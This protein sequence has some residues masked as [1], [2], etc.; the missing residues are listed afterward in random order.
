VPEGIPFIF[1]VLFNIPIPITVLQVLAI[2]LGTEIFP[3]LALGAEKPEPGIMGLPPRPKKKGVI[4]KIVLFRG[5]IVLGMLSTIATLGAYYLI[6]FQGGWRPGMQL[7]P[8][9]T[10]FTNPLHLKAM[11]V[12]FVG[13]IVMQVANVFNCRSEKYSAFRVGF[14]SNKRIFWSITISLAFTCILIYVPFFQK[15][16][17][18]IGIGWKDWAILVAFMIIIFLLEELRKKIW[19]PVPKI[20]R[21]KNC[22][23]N[24]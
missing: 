6:L 14:F 19:Q 12:L 3:A 11:T 18:T 23:H 20:G 16:F 13:I 21:R 8:N 4:D 9:D 17:Q 2:D 15:I 1:Y 5:Y 7:E 24:P 22:I 10:T